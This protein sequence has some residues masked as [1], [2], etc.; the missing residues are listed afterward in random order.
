MSNSAVSSLLMNTKNAL[1][2]LFLGMLMHVTPA[3]AQSL[4]ASD[5]QIVET[6]VRTVWLEFMG[7]VIGGIGSAYLIREAAVRLPVM[8]T[9]LAPARLWRSVAVKGEAVQI[10]VGARVGVS[11]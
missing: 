9:L 8:L 7:W 4:A 3:F 2:F 6:S 5:S 10:P 1:G 11:S